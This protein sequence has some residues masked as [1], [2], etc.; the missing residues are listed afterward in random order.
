MVLIIKFIDQEIEVK[1]DI[2]FN[3]EMGVWVVEFIKNYM[4]KYLLLFYLILVL[5]Q[6]FLQRD[7]NE[8]FIG[9]I[10]LYSLILMVISF[11]QLYLRIDVWRVDE[12]FGMFFVEFFEFYGRNFN[13]LK[14]GI[15]IKEGGV[16][17]VKEEIMKVMISGYRLLMLCIEDFLL[18]GNDVGWS[19]YG[20]MQVKQVFDYVY[21]VFSYVVLLLVRFYLN[22]DVESI[23]GRIIKVIQEVID[24]WR[25]IKEKW[26]SKVYLLLGMDNRIKI[27]E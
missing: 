1:V 17:I 15:R 9:G 26:G 25:W 5:K 20:V 21:I 16:Y 8:V 10:S 13:Y 24:Y 14:I 7:L 3:M 23:L 6:F 19:F 27:K 12:N 4:K 11:L 22:R 2:S 18:L